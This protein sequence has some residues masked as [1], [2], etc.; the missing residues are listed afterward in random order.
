MSNT[1]A[2]AAG[3]RNYENYDD[4]YWQ[5]IIFPECIYLR[6]DNPQRSWPSIA[7]HVGHPLLSVTFRRKFNQYQQ[8]GSTMTKPR[9]RPSKKIR[10]E[11]R[12][13]GQ[14]EQEG[15]G[16]VEGETNNSS[17]TAAANNNNNDNN[18]G[19][20]F[21]GGGEELGT[22]SDSNNYGCDSSDDD[23]SDDN[24]NNSSSNNISDSSD[25]N[26][27]N[28][29]S[30]TPK[31]RIS[32]TKRVPDS[33]RKEATDNA[34][35]TWQALNVYVP[36]GG[37]VID[38]TNGEGVFLKQ[39]STKRKYNCVHIDKYKNETVDAEMYAGIFSYTSDEFQ[40]YLTTKDASA[41]IMDPPYCT[42]NG[43]HTIL[44]CNIS[45]S[46]SRIIFNTRYGVQYTYNNEMIVAIFSRAFYWADKVLNI[47]GIFL[48]K[49]T[50]E[51][52]GFGQMSAVTL[53][54]DLW[55]FCIIDTFTL[56]NSNPLHN[57]SF[58][59]VL[60]RKTLTVTKGN[61]TK[62]KTTQSMKDMYYTDRENHDN[63]RN[64]LC[65]INT[66]ATEAFV[67]ATKDSLK[68]GKLWANACYK[69]AD[70]LTDEQLT[71]AMLNVHY[72]NNS[73]Q[74]F[75]DKDEEIREKLEELSNSDNQYCWEDLQDL[76]LSSERIFL[77]IKNLAG[78]LFEQLLLGR[79]IQIDDQSKKTFKAKKKI[80]RQI[81]GKNIGFVNAKS[82][83]A[84]S[85]NIKSFRGEKEWEEKR[86]KN[87]TDKRQQET[88]EKQ[89]AHTLNEWLIN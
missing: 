61:T 44:N 31:Q 62:T 76:A 32:T 41:F 48:L 56:K 35:L 42:I 50:R 71:N 55:N 77:D 24:T 58:L 37:I 38:G 82:H 4:D 19:P 66:K 26:S 53:L 11:S 73:L 29:N 40:Q 47:N 17:S 6:T 79:R 36:K 2:V 22:N 12:T 54:A 45:K 9:G 1:A 13:I 81:I 21:Q 52:K 25:S 7:T 70:I 20:Q 84:L 51:N 72:L 63:T 89:Q 69:L 34:K 80:E 60:K 43:R 5:E 8:T 88:K 18:D 83:H 39:S 3:Q 33:Q 75:S 27:D 30:P 14:E 59:L 65:K 64:M 68:L 67:K 87:K 28:N 85:S 10:T 15:E 46:R 86:R 16:D 74:M 23:D 78:L 57:D 49:C